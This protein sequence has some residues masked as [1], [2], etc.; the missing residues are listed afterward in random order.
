MSAQDSTAL[1]SLQR[2]GLAIQPFK[3]CAERLVVGREDSVCFTSHNISI[4]VKILALS[5]C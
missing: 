1:G 2:E 4:I 3:S 5:L